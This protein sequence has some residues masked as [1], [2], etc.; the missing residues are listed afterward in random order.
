[1]LFIKKSIN[2]K[3]VNMQLRGILISLFLIICLGCGPTADTTDDTP[4]FS[5]SLAYSAE[6]G[7]TAGSTFTVDLPVADAY[8]GDG[9]MVDDFIEIPNGRPI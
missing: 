1:M 9:S 2:L 6:C 4:N 7:G 5:Q 3:E 8:A